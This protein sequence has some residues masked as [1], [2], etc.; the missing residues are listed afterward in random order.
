MVLNGGMQNTTSLGALMLELSTYMYPRLPEG[1]LMGASN[2]TI[3]D[4]NVAWMIKCIDGCVARYGASTVIIPEPWLKEY[5]LFTQ[6]ARAEHR[7]SGSNQVRNN[8]NNDNNDDDNN[9]DNNDDN[10]GH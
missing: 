6:L 7:H 5:D 2:A 1:P 4:Q 3:L 10:N 9:N 8:D